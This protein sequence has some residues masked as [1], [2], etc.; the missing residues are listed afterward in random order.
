MANYLYL[1]SQAYIS[2][3]NKA[4]T[5]SQLLLDYIYN[6]NASKELFDYYKLAIYY[7]KNWSI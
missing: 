1:S 7:Y 6:N 2:V 4:S 5:E 3:L